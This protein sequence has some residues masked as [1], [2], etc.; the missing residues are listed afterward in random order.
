MRDERICEAAPEVYTATDWVHEGFQP[1]TFGLQSWSITSHTEE[2]GRKRHIA[3]DSL[4]DLE[5][6]TPLC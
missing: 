2:I 5:K 3:L 6:Y 4:G 1:R